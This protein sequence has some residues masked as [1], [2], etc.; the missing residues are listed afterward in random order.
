M[1]EKSPPP[2]S[3]GRGPAICS[4][5]GQL[6]SQ[7][8]RYGLLWLPWRLPAAG[9]EAK[10]GRRL[11]GARMIWWALL[12]PIFLPYLKQTRLSLWLAGAESGG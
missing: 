10:G 7:T 9:L 6:L 11:C 5:S 12:S 1:L 2:M 4:F 8:S 3:T